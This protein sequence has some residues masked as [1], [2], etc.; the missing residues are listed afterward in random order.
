MYFKIQSVAQIRPRLQV[1]ATT[2]CR[3]SERNTQVE[4]KN[5]M[6]F[7]YWYTSYIQLA[8]GTAFPGTMISRVSCAQRLRRLLRPPPAASPASAT[9]RVSRETP[10]RA[11]SPAASRVRRAPRPPRAAP[12]AQ[13]VFRVRHY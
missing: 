13:S 4:L 5:N 11:A 12:A 8:R 9:R 6:E 10:P 7:E 3:F 2:K 1:R